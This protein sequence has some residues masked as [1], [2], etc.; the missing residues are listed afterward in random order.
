MNSWDQKNKKDLRK[1]KTNKSLKKV[2]FHVSESVSA[3][4]LT[5]VEFFNHF[6]KYRPVTI[7]VPGGN[8]P[9]KFFNFLIYHL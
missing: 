3:A 6:L 1:T 4:T 7:L 8:T 2:E 5:A 9:K